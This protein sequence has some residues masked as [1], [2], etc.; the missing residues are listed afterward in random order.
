MRLTERSRE[1]MPETR[2]QCT[3]MVTMVMFYYQYATTEAVDHRDGDVRWVG[4]KSYKRI[5]VLMI[6][7]SHL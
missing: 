7:V 2:R 6:H 1:L 3:S 5:H 4:A